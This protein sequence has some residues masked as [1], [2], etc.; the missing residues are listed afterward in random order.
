MCGAC[1]VHS[2]VNMLRVQTASSKSNR[3]ATAAKSM[4]L[5]APEGYHTALRILTAV[6]F[7][8][9]TPLNSGPHVP[10]LQQLTELAE[11]SESVKRDVQH[12]VSVVGPLITPAIHAKRIEHP[13]FSSAVM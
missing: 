12:L 2:S 10:L 7:H 1:R 4:D 8:P 9:R 6:A 13:A 3:S 11:T 5:T